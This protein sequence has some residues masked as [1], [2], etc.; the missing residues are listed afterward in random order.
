LLTDGLN[1]ANNGRDATNSLLNAFALTVSRLKMMFSTMM[2]KM[3][4]H[5]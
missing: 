3:M 4:F 5:F 2:T 1:V